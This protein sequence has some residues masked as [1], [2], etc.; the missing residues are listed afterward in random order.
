MKKYLTILAACMLALIININFSSCSKDDDDEFTG[1]E[2]TGGNQQDNNKPSGDNQKDDDNKPDEDEDND[3]NDDD[4]PI[5]DDEFVE[6]CLLWG[7]NAKEI[8]EWMKQ[9]TQGFDISI[10]QANYLT[11]VREEP[12]IGFDYYLTN[13]DDHTLYMVSVLYQECSDAQKILDSVET[14]YNCKLKDESTDNGIVRYT[15]DDVV[16][17]DKKTHIFIYIT[18]LLGKFKILIGYELNE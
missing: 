8:R 11:F 10:E 15:A 12:T 9:N 1:Q 5:A 3:D 4:K 2:Q 6:P 13:S 18:P 7:A 14:I 17:N 16:I